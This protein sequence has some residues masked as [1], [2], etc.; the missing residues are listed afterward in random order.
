MQ[1]NID[2]DRLQ[3]S[4]RIIQAEIH[5]DKFVSGSQIEKESII[6]KVYR[7]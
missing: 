3:K 5:P 4:Y 6:N 1:F 2:L 7:G